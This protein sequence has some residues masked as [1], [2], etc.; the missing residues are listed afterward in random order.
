M[1]ISNPLALL[2]VGRRKDAQQPGILGIDLEEQYHQLPAPQ[3]DYPFAEETTLDVHGWWL[4]S[5]PEGGSGGWHEEA[6]DLMA[7]YRGEVPRQVGPATYRVLPRPLLRRPASRNIRARFQENWCQWMMHGFH[8]TGPIHTTRYRAR[9][10]QKAYRLQGIMNYSSAEKRLREAQQL[11]REQPS[12]VVSLLRAQ[13]KLPADCPYPRL[14]PQKLSS[15][16][17]AFQGGS[18]GFRKNLL[19]ELARLDSSSPTPSR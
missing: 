11:A 3:S 2:V 14:P 5:P 12:L 1:T 4:G 18:P 15:A 7:P 19:R 13:N 16:L 9:T 17:M 10:L 6:R 8:D